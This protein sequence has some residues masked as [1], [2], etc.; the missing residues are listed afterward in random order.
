MET[1]SIKACSPFKSQ[2]WNMKRKFTIFV[3]DDAAVDEHVASHTTASVSHKI[4]SLSHSGNRM[5]YTTL[6]RTL[7]RFIDE[8][9]V[10]SICSIIFYFFTK[11]GSPEAYLEEGN[12]R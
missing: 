7:I 12:H 11:H 5:G 4:S 3:N 6:C 8:S 10:C 9:F 2:A 1:F